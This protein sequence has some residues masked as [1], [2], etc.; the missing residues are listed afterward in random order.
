ML[1]DA[2][3]H[4][5]MLFQF[6]LLWNLVTYSQIFT[7]TLYRINVMRRQRRA[8]SRWLFAERCSQFNVLLCVLETA[9]CLF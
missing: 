2:V 5:T 8:H 6:K 1:R 7:Y 3:S 4:S 9:E